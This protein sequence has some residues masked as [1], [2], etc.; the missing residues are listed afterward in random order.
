MC[1]SI[2]ELPWQA[3]ISQWADSLSLARDRCIGEEHPIIR[4][5]ILCWDK[6]LLQVIP[7]IRLSFITINLTN[8]MPYVMKTL[9]MR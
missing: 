5:V 1:D 4:V 7:S 9:S 8:E 2:R 6:Q 3:G